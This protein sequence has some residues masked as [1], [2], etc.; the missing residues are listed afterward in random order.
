MGDVGVLGAEVRLEG[1]EV[2]DVAGLVFLDGKAMRCFPFGAHGVR[3]SQVGCLPA[4]VAGGCP[5][6]YQLQ[7]RYRPAALMSI[8]NFRK[9]YR[10]AFYRAT[11]PGDATIVT[12]L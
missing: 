9:S 1:D 7:K 10:R 2:R 12:S 5:L 6:L 8:A 3:G 4:T 11:S